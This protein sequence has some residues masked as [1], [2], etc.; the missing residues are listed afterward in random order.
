MPPL[1]NALAPVCHIHRVGL[2]YGLLATAMN[3]LSAIINS[4]CI[5]KYEEI[6]SDYSTEHINHN[7]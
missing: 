1:L 3:L 5:I 6:Q 4:I 7:L 2:L